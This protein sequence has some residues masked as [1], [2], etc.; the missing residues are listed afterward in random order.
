[1]R[2]HMNRVFKERVEFAVVTSEETLNRSFPLIALQHINLASHRTEGENHRYIYEDELNKLI[3]EI[4]KAMNKSERTVKRYIKKIKES[5]ARLLEIV[6]VDG[7]NKSYFKINY[8][9]NGTKFVRVGEQALKFMISHLTNTDFNIFM[10][11]AVLV[12]QADKTTVITREAIAEK[13]GIERLDTVTQAIFVLVK[14]GLIC[15]QKNT[16]TVN[17]VVKTYNAYSIPDYI[18]IE[19]FTNKSYYFNAK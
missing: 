17:G 13:V 10:T 9:N 7:T 8:T 6:P 19:D 14:L 18:D 5:G 3:P 15:V 4:A 2:K 12:S 16:T 11:M 1:M